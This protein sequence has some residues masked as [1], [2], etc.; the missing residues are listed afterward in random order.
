MG[1]RIN[2]NVASITARR[3][4]SKATMSLGRNYQRLSTGKRIAQASDDAAGLSISTRMRKDIRSIDQAARNAQDGVS[5]V[6]TAEGAL[7]EIE[8]AMIRMRELAVQAKNGTL[9]SSD[10][11]TL[12]KE[13]QELNDTIQNIAD[14]SDFNGIKLL[15]GTSSTVDLQIGHNATT[16]DVHSVSLANATTT[17]LTLNALDIGSTGDQSLAISSLD[18]AINVISD[19]RADF[20]AAQNRLEAAISNLEVKSENLSAANSRILDVDVAAETAALTKNSILQ[21]SAISILAQANTQPQAALSLL[22]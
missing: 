20:G 2:T 9:N 6:Q 13:F 3:H 11:D 22:G 21:Q 4:M 7:A 19:A 15:D 18:T 17:A 5:L 10:K 14:T 12:Q 16:N 8:S 1:L